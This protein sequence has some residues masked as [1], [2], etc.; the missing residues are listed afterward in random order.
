MKRNQHLLLIFLLFILS[1]CNIGS[2]SS[3]P[4]PTAVA[5]N[6]EI[7]TPVLSDVEVTPRSPTVTAIPA[8]TETLAFTPTSTPTPRASVV[9]PTRTP[10]K[11][12][13]AAT[14]TPVPPMAKIL[15]YELNVRA[16]PGPIYAPIGALKQGESV[17]ITGVNFTDEWYQ[18]ARN[19]E[20]IGWISASPTYIETTPLV[21]DAPQ[22]SAPAVPSGGGKLVLQGK[23]GGDFYLTNADGSNLRRISHGIDPALSPDGSKIAFTRWDNNEFGSVWIYDLNSGTEWPIVGEIR[24]AKSPTWSPDGMQLVINYQNG[25]R[26]EIERRCYSMRK[27]GSF[28]QPPPGAYDIR[29]R[30]FKLCFNLFPDTHWQLRKIDAVTGKFEDLA[31]ATYSFA[32]TW[33]PANPWRI[34]FAGSKGL[35]QLDLNR[36]EYWPFGEAD[37]RDHA[38]VFSPDG[39][40]VAVTYKQDNHWEIYTV[41]ARDG[42]RLRLTK[43]EPMLEQP[44]GSAA[45]V[46]SPNGKKIAF[47]SDRGGQWAF[48]IMNSDGT[49]PRPLLLPEAAA[50]IEVEYSGV[51]ERLISWSQ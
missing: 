7:S 5:L 33:D 20:T 47:I 9:L 13:V 42:S 31:S 48:W 3:P 14:P 35:L 36:N 41:D 6:A 17:E 21:V 23:S 10:A 27:D 29:L 28:R 44:A 25:G 18:V 38:P 43:S 26:R 4:T 50:Q 45:P 11:T 51:D 40:K 30:G 15:S 24:E 46:W 16:G 12:P 19:G 49:D 2:T 37:F 39:S 1:A 8:P 32:P 34:V 22:V